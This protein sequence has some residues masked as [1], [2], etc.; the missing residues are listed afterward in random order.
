MNHPNDVRPPDANLSI[1]P[2]VDP[3]VSQEVC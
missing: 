1:N 3:G 2:N